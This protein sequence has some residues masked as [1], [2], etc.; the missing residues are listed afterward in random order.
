MNIL[1]ET[2]A[3]ILI[4]AKQLNT[5]MSQEKSHASNIA[6]KIDRTYAH[7]IKQVESLEE[8]GL[9]KK[10]PKTG[11]S[12]EI[13]VTEKGEKAAKHAQRLSQTLEPAGEAA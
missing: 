4:A 12:K 7:V 9:V 6:S 8:L 2:Q 5:A 1:Q 10:A 11:R 13:R 3:E